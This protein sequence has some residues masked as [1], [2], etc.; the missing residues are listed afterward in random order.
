MADF[1]ADGP[2]PQPSDDE[3]E[4]YYRTIKRHRPPSSPLSLYPAPGELPVGRS[5]LGWSQEEF[6]SAAGLEVEIIIDYERRG[7]GAAEKLKGGGFCMVRRA[8]E[9]AGVQFWPQGIRRCPPGTS[10]CYDEIAYAE[11]VAA[12]FIRFGELHVA[13]QATGLPN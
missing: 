2:A 4:A 1:H 3:A 8:F 12:S 13:E 5:M 11:I 6:A 9:L 10:P 7:F